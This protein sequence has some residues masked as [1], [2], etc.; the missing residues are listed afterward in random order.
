LAAV[1]EEPV[2][3]PAIEVRDLARKL[4]LA[5][6]VSIIFF[7]VSGGPY[8]LEDTIG[9]SGPGMGLLLII[10]TPILWAL[11]ASLMVAELATAM[12]VQG[13]YYYWVKTGLGPFWG[14]QEGWWS[15]VTSWVDLA[16]YPVL[17]VDYSAYF[18]P[19]LGENA[20]VRW[21]VAFVIIWLFAFLNMRGTS[22][23]GDSSKVFLVIV[24]AP[25]VLMTVIGLFKMDHNPFEPFTFPGVGLLPAFGAGLFVIMWNYMGWDGLS[26]VAGEIDNPRRDYPR[27]L[28]I[29]IPAITLIYLLPTLVALAVGG[30]SDIEWTAGAYNVIAE[31][32]AGKWLGT[33]MTI[34]AVISAVG[35][36]SAWLLQYSRIPSALAE[37]GYLPERV[38][39]FHPRWGTPVWAITICA[40][41]CSVAA[42]G[43]FQS[44]VVVD[45][46]IYA[47]ALLLQFA[48]LI[49]LRIKHPNLKRPYRIPGGWLGLVLVTL[50]PIFVLFVAV[51]YQVLDVGLVQGIGWA[52]IG[53]GT[54][55]IAYYW[56][57][58]GKR[59][60]GI[61][62]TIELEFDEPDAPTE[63]ST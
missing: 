37:D 45:V 21:L 6:I 26:T 56:L 19:I 25:F 9:E 5:A 27:A 23:I 10:I 34:G 1:S 24:L 35:L 44:L 58:I 48:A 62:H 46:T 52:L 17:F 28:A 40:I 31:S 55:P 49:A 51:Y 43:P 4:G 63:V 15:W 14:F 22:L 7:S 29:T 38:S 18:F 33:F 59:R 36:Y 32:V 20:L 16:I 11:P 2:A 8:G 60:K 41:I 3:R 13:G 54:G 47:F 12:P 57:R 42:L 39:R 53:M 61:D 50:G 30:T